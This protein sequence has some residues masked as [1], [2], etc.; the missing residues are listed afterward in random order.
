MTHRVVLQY[1]LCAVQWIT[2]SWAGLTISMQ[3]C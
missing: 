3:N 2:D 1:L